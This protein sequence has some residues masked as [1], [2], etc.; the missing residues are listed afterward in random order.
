[1]E[2]LTIHQ[3]LLGYSEVKIPPSLDKS[4]LLEPTLTLSDQNEGYALFITDKLGEQSGTVDLS[5]L[6]SFPS[7]IVISENRKIIAGSCPV[8]RVSNPRKALAYAIYNASNIASKKTKFIAVTGTAGKT[9]TATLIYQILLKS[10]N[11]VGFIG[12]GKILSGTT[13]IS[14]DFYSMTT[15]DPTLLYPTIAKMQSDGCNYIVMEVSSHSLAL[16]KTAPIIFD[17]AIFTNLDSEHLDFHSSMD[18]YFNTKLSLFENTKY[19]LFNLDDTYSKMAYNLATCKKSSFGIIHPGDA[20]AT[21]ISVGNVGEISFFYR[22]GPIFFKVNSHLIGAF[23]AYNLISAIKC[24]I[25][26]GIKP[27]VAKK[28]L[29]SVS[30]IDGRMEILNGK[31]TGIIDYA[32]TPLAFLN[33]LKAL[34]QRVKPKQNLIVVFGCGGN[35]DKNKRS[36]F[37]EYA[38]KYADKIIITEDNNRNESFTSIARD[39][40]NGIHQNYFDII[41]DREAAIRF[42]FDQAKPGD[43]VAVIGKGH[44]KYIIS[45]DQYL[46][47]NEKEIMLDCIA[48]KEALC[49]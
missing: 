4:I 37:G 33:C 19:G 35:R 22:D 49:E 48:K 23:N 21:E 9:T 31:V 44:E 7:A 15:P 32:H 14:D 27:C 26:L 5:Y 47:F 11:K 10:G 24:T 41:P 2:K 39:I 16:A 3:L 45:A 36:V 25:D 8:I 1:M 38:D 30:G 29:E 20:C 18:E 43:I 6:K 40:T 28:A 46:P 13:K 34:K 17:Y 12:T 42:A